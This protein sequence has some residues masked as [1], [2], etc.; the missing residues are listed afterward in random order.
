MQRSGLSELEYE[1]ELES[2]DPYGSELDE[3][4]DDDRETDDSEYELDDGEVDEPDPREASPDYAELEI[5]DSQTE[6]D[7]SELDEEIEEPDVHGFAERFYELSLREFES[8]IE[9]DHEVNRL[10][11]EME[12]EY[13]FGSLGKLIKGAGRQLIKKGIAYVKS[14]VPIA[15]VVK[16]VTALARGNLRGVLESVAKTA[17]GALSSHPAFAALLPAIQAL[18][19]SGHGGAAGSKDAWANFV[20]LAKDSY[21]QLAQNLTPNADQPAEAAR[22]AGKSYEVA[23]RR[24]KA[25]GF[26]ARPTRHDHRRQHTKTRAQVV[27]LRPGARLVIKVVG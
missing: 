26:G 13:F 19:F 20:K 14:R 22:I 1:L 3:E 23:L 25:V 12:R 7:D 6:L 18:G 15:N 21:G 8:E 4:L 17:L 11:G 27:V 16:G 10:L 24:Q 9:I 5:V 2:E